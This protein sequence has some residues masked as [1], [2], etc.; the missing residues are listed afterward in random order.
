VG[1]LGNKRHPLV[2]SKN[3]KKRNFLGHS[4][5]NTFEVFELP[6]I[7]ERWHLVEPSRMPHGI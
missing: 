1:A 5:D 6:Q 3:L 4:K 7:V 2:S